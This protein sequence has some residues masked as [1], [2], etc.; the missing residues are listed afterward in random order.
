MHFQVAL[1]VCSQSVLA[2]ARN[3]HFTSPEGEGFQP[4]PKET[5]NIQ[6]PPEGLKENF[7]WL[8]YD[9]VLHLQKRDD[10]PITSAEFAREV[11]GTRLDQTASLWRMWT[12]ILGAQET[13]TENERARFA[14]AATTLETKSGNNS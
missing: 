10:Q 11:V 2:H 3:L 7:S 9:Q 5:L 1:G 14:T 8:R 12:G 13:I 6:R 4:S